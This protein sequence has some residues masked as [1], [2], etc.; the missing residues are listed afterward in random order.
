MRTMGRTRYLLLAAFS[1]SGVLAAHWLG[2]RATAGPHDHDHHATSRLLA[3]T[4]HNYFNYFT[5]V[6]VG[7]SMLFLMLY[8]ARR[9]RSTAVES[10]G[11]S[12]VRYGA[13]RLLPVQ[14]VAFVG[15]ELVER[16]L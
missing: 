13:L 8:V 11:L 15:L 6:V 1:G 14:A 3:E 7:L 10:G 2:Y 5:A 12:L 9:L 4:G 16:S